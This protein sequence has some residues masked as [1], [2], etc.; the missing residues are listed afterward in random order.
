MFSISF[1]IDASQAINM[2]YNVFRKNAA[3]GF[4]RRGKK[5]D[6]VNILF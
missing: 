2:C 5:E 3:E 1:A 4:A 6:C